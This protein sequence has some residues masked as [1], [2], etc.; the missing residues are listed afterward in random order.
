MNE[1]G[2]QLQDYLSVRRALGH[3]LTETGRLLGQFVAYCGQSGT[4]VVTTD[5]AVAW[6]TL[7]IGADP[8][9]WAQ[10]LSKV[11]GFATWLQ[12]LDPATEVPPTD[13]LTGRPRR[14]VPY[15]YT[16]A[17]LS[18]IMAAAHRVRSPL[19]QQTYQTL[20]GLLAVTGLRVGEVIRL[21]RGDVCLDSGLVRVIRSK[22]NKSREVPLH[23]TT[24]E[25]LHR[26]VECRDRLCP[27]RRSE[28][29]F[30]STAGTRLT[31]S[32]VRSIFHR[33]VQQADLRPRAGRC[34]PRIHDFRHSLA[35]AILT[36]WYRDR[37]DV[38]ARLPLLS[39]WLGHVNPEATYWYLSA[40]PE[41][42]G[43]ASRRLEDRFEGDR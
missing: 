33:L 35:C 12:T 30:L 42:L 17:E 6:A 28:S 2:S 29:F 26:Y 34:R 41:L 11:R 4:P 32:V 36:G 7:P 22:F 3:K 10:R 31:Y 9:W 21:N 27:Q 23:P 14:A 25:A 19:Q 13:I 18:A 1:L 16:D 5:I 40:V 20:V 24:V 38:Q 39:T 15:L 43:L 37:V 8:S